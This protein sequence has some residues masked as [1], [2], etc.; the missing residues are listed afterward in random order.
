MIYSFTKSL[1][2]G[3]F[4]LNNQ[5][6]YIVSYNSCNERICGIGN[7][8]CSHC[9]RRGLHSNHVLEVKCVMISFLPLVGYNSLFI[10]I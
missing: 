1:I 10:I 5:F 7:C 6:C 2:H 3:L 8:F 9:D 4:S